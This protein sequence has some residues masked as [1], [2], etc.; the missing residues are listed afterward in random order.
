M[1]L[2]R[3]NAL[4]WNITPPF[5]IFAFEIEEKKIFNHINTKGH[6]LNN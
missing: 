6:N 5:S 3:E 4:T 2:L 1:A